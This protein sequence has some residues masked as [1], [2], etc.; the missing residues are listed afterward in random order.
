MANLVGKKVGCQMSTEWSVVGRGVEVRLLFD[1]FSAAGPSPDFDPRQK[2][3][4]FERFSVAT[5]TLAPGRLIR[6]GVLLNFP[7]LKVR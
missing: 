3:P 1:F 5:N 2:L 4:R 7:L 6:R